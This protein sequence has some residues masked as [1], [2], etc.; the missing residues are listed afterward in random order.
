MYWYTPAIF[1]RVKSLGVPGTFD[2]NVI[3]PAG[4]PNTVKPL[5]KDILS[6]SCI[7]VFIVENLRIHPITAPAEVIVEF[8][9]IVISDVPDILLV[10]DKVILPPTVSLAFT[11]R[12]PVYPVVVKD[13]TVTVAAPTVH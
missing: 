9:L 11:I 12:L 1:W 4:V 10:L 13:S 2:L 8:V 7:V 5:L 6:A 3:N